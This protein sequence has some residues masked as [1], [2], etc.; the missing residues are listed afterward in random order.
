M[1]VL[2]LSAVEALEAFLKNWRF[3]R[4]TW[5]LYWNLLF[6]Y[7]YKKERKKQ[8]AYFPDGHFKFDSLIYF[9]LTELPS[10]ILI[11]LLCLPK[12]IIYCIINS[13]QA[14]TVP[15]LFIKNITTTLYSSSQWRYSIL[16]KNQSYIEL[17]ST[18]TI[19]IN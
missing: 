10:S 5:N 16:L 17:I 15:N 12:A 3:C 4:T 18:S 1:E 14:V 13:A 8:D 6:L 9:W 11:Q 19:K 7:S 2:S